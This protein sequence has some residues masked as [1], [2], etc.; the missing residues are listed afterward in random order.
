MFHILNLL[1]ILLLIAS[2]ALCI[3]SLFEGQILTRQVA[4]PPS[5]G[6]SSQISALGAGV[7]EGWGTLF[8]GGF[9]SGSIAPIETRVV[10]WEWSS[11]SMNEINSMEVDL[12]P[13]TVRLPGIL[14]YRFTSGGPMSLTGWM[15][16][17][18]FGWL[19]PLFSLLPT[20]WL[21]NRHKEPRR[22]AKLGLC[23]AC[24]YDL[25]GSVGVCPECGAISTSKAPAKLPPAPDA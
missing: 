12:Q 20:Y 14:L 4:Y 24:G 17:I 11:T 3:Y 19:I 16:T 1:S 23:L 22:R 21:L 18:H 5:G 15:I 8:W 2:V 7:T 9:D 25:R 13:Q 6:A 10:E